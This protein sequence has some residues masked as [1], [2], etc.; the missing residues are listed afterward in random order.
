MG[1]Q[2]DMGGCNNSSHTNL[3]RPCRR[4]SAQACACALRNTVAAETSVCKPHFD[5][6]CAAK[7]LHDTTA[8][9]ANDDG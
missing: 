8:N 9:E 2:W 3:S 5:Y 4:M 1:E 7:K 6:F